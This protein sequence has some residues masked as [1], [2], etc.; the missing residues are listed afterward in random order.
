MVV[1]LHTR[2]LADDAVASVPREMHDEADA[3]GDERADRR[4]GQADVGLQPAGGE[5]GERLGGRVRVDRSE[6][7]GVAGALSS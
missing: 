1:P 3:V 5:T 6:R 4:V 2:Q 7:A